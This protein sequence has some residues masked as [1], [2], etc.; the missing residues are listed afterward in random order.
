MQPCVKSTHQPSLQ[1]L[2][3][4]LKGTTSNGTGNLVDQFWKVPFAKPP[5][6]ALR[7]APPQPSVSWSGIRNATHSLFFCPQYPFSGNGLEPSKVSAGSEDC[8]YLN[9]FRPRKAAT[10]K[11]PVMVSTMLHRGGFILYSLEKCRQGATSCTKS[12]PANHGEPPFLFSLSIWLFDIFCFF[13]R[14]QFSSL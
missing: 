13:N 6:G 7:F 2:S 9:I 12:Y 1:I 3:L 11:M 5:V 8:L 4:F 10:R 14:S